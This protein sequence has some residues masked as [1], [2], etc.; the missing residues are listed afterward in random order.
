[1]QSTASAQTMHAPKWV[2]SDS[3]FTPSFYKPYEAAVE[4]AFLMLCAARTQLDA[5][6]RQQGVRAM[7]FRLKSPRS[8]RDKLTR[9]NLAP[10]AE[11]A[12]STLHDVAG[13]RVVLGNVESV[14]CFARLL[15]ES[16]VAQYAGMRDYIASPK[17]SGYRSLHLIMRIPVHVAGHSMMVPVEI[18]LRTAA[19]DVWA[20]IE[21]DAIYKPIH[22]SM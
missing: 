4:T 8:I 11:A 15:R 2:M 16:T 20:T 14:Y 19:M 9:R 1:M 22:A 18:Q 13:L 5:M 6:G 7:T 21:H 3:V 17:R 10:T 12:S